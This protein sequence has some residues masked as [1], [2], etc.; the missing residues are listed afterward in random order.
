MRKIVAGLF[1]SAG[2]A[3]S[4]VAGAAV[5]NGQIFNIDA[6]GDGKANDLKISQVMFDV[7][8]GTQVFFDSLAWESENQDLNGDGLT[9]AFDSYLMVFDAAGKNLFYADDSNNTFGDGSTNRLDAAQRW[10]F[11]QAGT[12]MVTIGRGT[13]FENEALQGFERNIPFDTYIGTENFGAW[14]LTMSAID[15]T[16]SRVAEVGAP[17]ADVPEPASL[18]LLG[19]GFAGLAA[20]RRKQQQ[21]A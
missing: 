4:S 16:L 14:R 21:S 8:A 17:S 2:M 13:Y 12:Y 5:I 10:T 18:L 9:T 1:L 19:A 3:I 15:G 7:T 20:S 11:S 6:D